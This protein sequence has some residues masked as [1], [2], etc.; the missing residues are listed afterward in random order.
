VA[1]ALGGEGA[2]V[3]LTGRTLEA[4]D[5]AP[6]LVDTAREIEAR[7]GRGVPL[8]VDHRVDAQVEAAFRR[9]QAE[10]GRL[11]IL[12]NNAFALPA[13]PLFGTPFWEQPID[14]WDT[15]HEVGLR[16]HYVASVFAAPLLFR[17]EGGL[18]AN[19]SSFGGAS[20]QVNVAYGVG[21]AGVDRL[22]ADMA[23][24][25]RS[26]GVTAVSLYPGIVRT[27]RV[28]AGELPFSTEVSESP[29]LTGRAVAAIALDPSRLDLSGQ[30]LV[31]AELAR[32]YGF[33]DVDGT[34]P[35][36]LAR[37]GRRR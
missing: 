17:A 22:A 33:T 8:E 26:R 24:D 19:V 4:K 18:V 32:R 3:Y 31:V 6:G 9:V 28:L 2:T 21:K 15:M 12:V 13:G 25:L 11:D 20:Y 37:A 35:P 36:S 34:Q 23:R 30:V 1:L 10:V 29:E 14:V 16:S 5:R 7:G 27:E